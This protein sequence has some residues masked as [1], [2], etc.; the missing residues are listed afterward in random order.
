MVTVEVEKLVPIPREYLSAC[1]GKPADISKAFTNGDLEFI[2]YGYQLNY[3]P[4]L[5][6][7]LNDIRKLNES[8]K[9]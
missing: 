5:E 1:P 3:V 4:C 7:R 9:P 6:S 2:A 8:G